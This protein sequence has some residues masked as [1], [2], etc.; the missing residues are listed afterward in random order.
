MG[1][2]DIPNF[3]QD[4]Q[5]FKVTHKTVGTLVKSKLEHNSLQSKKQEVNIKKS[6][7]TYQTSL[8]LQQILIYNI[9]NRSK[10]KLSANPS[11]TK[12]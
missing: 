4:T 2:A 10:T 6:S 7:E 5:S 1:D 11:Q 3:T 12:P 9:Q 8:G